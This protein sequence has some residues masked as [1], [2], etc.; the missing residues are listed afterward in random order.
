MRGKGGWKC[1][2]EKCGGLCVIIVG[3]PVM[4]VWCAGSWDL[5]L[6][7]QGDVS[8][9]FHYVYTPNENMCMGVMSASKFVRMVPA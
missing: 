1:V 5:K 4:L 2:L 7:H 9:F 6:I 8:F 3:V